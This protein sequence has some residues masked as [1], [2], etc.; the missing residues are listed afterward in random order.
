MYQREVS[1]KYEIDILL[2]FKVKSQIR[3]EN[4]F[5]QLLLRGNFCIWKNNI[6]THNE[7]QG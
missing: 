7:D 1:K 3:N 6:Q 5:S 2:K 4:G